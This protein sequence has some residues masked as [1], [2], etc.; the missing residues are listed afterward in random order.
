MYVY[1]C[2]YMYIYI[3]IYIYT[4]TEEKEAVLYIQFYQASRGNPGA[5]LFDKVLQLCSSYP[6]PIVVSVP[7]A[8]VAFRPEDI[9]KEV[10][11]EFEWLPGEKSATPHVKSPHREF[12][13]A[14][15]VGAPSL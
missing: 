9:D 10:Q 11:E 12:S 6:G 7:D 15:Y 8:K 4:D 14:P 1:V 2:V 3:Y 13:A 5:E